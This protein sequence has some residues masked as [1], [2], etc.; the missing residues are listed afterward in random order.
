MY[1][2]RGRSHI[3]FENR[4]IYPTLSRFRAF[5]AVL[6]RR[7]LM[8]QLLDMDMDLTANR[9]LVATTCSALH[10]EWHALGGGISPWTEGKH[11]HSPNRRCRQLSGQRGVFLGTF[12]SCCFFYS[13]LVMIDWVL[14]KLWR[15]LARMNY[16]F[17]V[18]KREP[19]WK[20]GGLQLALFRTC[21]MEWFQLPW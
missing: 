6:S 12:C 11:K 20:W 8:V 7:V 4:I 15:L 3:S 10:A 14:L 17:R 2:R 18:T 13:F 21:C 5:P 16:N 9:L 1:I 19:L